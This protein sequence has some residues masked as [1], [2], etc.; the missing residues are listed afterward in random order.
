MCSSVEAE[1]TE[2]LAKSG[3]MQSELV[4]Q[5][6]TERQ[7]V[8]ELQS[9]ETM[10]REWRV[11]A[12]GSGAELSALRRTLQDKEGELALAYQRLENAAKERALLHKLSTA[13]QDLEG[14]KAGGVD[15]VEARATLG[16]RP[17][18]SNSNNVVPHSNG[19]TIGASPAHGAAHGNGSAA[20]LN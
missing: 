17:R 11:R 7:R 6:A 2:A 19:S 10:Y 20:G 4:T 14:L 18:T 8:K 9:Y 5:L 1:L 16:A 15:E 12:Q 13:Q 3:A